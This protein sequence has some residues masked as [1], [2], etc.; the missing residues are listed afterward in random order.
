[1]C[2]AVPVKI[3]SLEVEQAI[4]DLGGVQR[5]VQTALLPEVKVGDF[6]LVHAG[7]AIKKWSEEDVREYWEIIGERNKL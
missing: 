2:L 4:V 6:V 1:M 5:K 3:V 7:F